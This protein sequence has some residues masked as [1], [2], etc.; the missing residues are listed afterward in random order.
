MRKNRTDKKSE[1]KSGFIIVFLTFLI[2]T[3]SIFLFLV[4]NDNYHKGIIIQGVDVGGLSITEA[5]TKIQNNFKEKL[6]DEKI[7]F[8]YADYNLE[9]EGREIDYSYDYKATLN[10]AYSLGRKGSYFE[11]IDTILNLYKNPIYI[12]VI[13]TYNEEKLDT[14]IDNI[15][16][17]IDKSPKDAEIFK[18]GNAFIIKDEKIALVLNVEKSKSIIVDK[19][20]N[21]KYKEPIEIEL[22]VEEIV[23]K[24]MATDLKKIKDLLGI[25]KTSFNSNNKNRTTNVTLS[26]KK[27]NGKVVM[28]QEIFSFNEVV[29]PRT[30]E[31]GYLS[32][33]VIFK[34]ELIDGF[35]GGV[36]QTSSTLYNAV[37]LS[38]LKIIQRSKHTIP[39]TYVPKGQDATVSYGVLDFKFQNTLDIPIYIESYVYKNEMIVKIYGKKVDDIDIKIESVIDEVVKRSI[40]T[41]DD[42]ELDEGIEKIEE[43]GRDGYKVTTYKYYYKNGKLIKKERLSKDYYRPTNQILIKGTKKVVAPIIDHNI[44]IENNTDIE[45]VI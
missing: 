16:K 23:P 31:K 27:M 2:I 9:I 39:S 20:K 5:Q 37:L 45:E 13:P 44:D 25:Y 35:G 18:K 24:V 1:F 43:K 34:G 33:H 4:S 6:S 15:K 40:E 10:E 8:K 12:E 22:L 17:N 41:K 26:A 11:R 3:T 28:P 21:H 30:E 29:G 36:C 7:R 32:A 42:H 19:L 14:I 38:N